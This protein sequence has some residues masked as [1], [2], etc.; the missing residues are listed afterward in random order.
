MFL[1][2]AEVYVADNVNAAAVARRLVFVGGDCADNVKH[3]ARRVGKAGY[4]AAVS[5][6]GIA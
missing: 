2:V 6:R 5:A 1:R 4:R 3:V